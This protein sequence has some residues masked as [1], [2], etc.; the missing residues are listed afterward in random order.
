MAMSTS[1]LAQEV[2]QALA[3]A[4]DAGALTSGTGTAPGFPP[5]WAEVHRR[6]ASDRMAAATLT[7]FESD[8][9]SADL[10][11]RLAAALAARLTS[12]ELHAL[13]ARLRGSHPPPQVRS[14]I[15]AG[16]DALI[17]G[18]GHRVIAPGGPVDLHTSAGPRS[19]I[20][21]SPI[22]IA[23]AG[24]GSA[25]A[26]LSSAAAA[27][28]RESPPPALSADGSHFT[29]G[30]ALLIGVSVYQTAY[31]NVPGGTTAQDARALAHLLRDPQR[32][33]YPEEQ[34]RV[35]LD[36]AAT[37]ARILAE[38]DAL[39]QRLA[40]APG[41]TAL[42]F[43]AGHGTPCGASYALLPHDANPVHLAATAVTA[44]LFHRAVAQVRAQ[45]RRLVVLLN[46]C[47]AG[48]VGD[49]VLDAGDVL[50]G[51]AP[52]PEFYRPL[53]ARTGPVVVSA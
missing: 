12:G 19:R 18:S 43:F 8:P 10:Q 14:Q 52:P 30:H 6:L 36:A 42:I 4:V 41:S 3:A 39:A 23:G 15:I 29:F 47:H 32:A 22:T 49:A 7:L 44:E 38:L 25:P 21:D 40:G 27:P 34:V 35:L 28:R 16:E 33:A 46:C 45:A 26:P 9:R 5:A 37:R 50:S 48:G 51:A 2:V 20:I 13:L 17:Q 24:A 11:R 31:L 1:T 53:A